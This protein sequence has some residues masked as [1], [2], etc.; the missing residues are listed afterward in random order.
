MKIAQF[1][2]FSFEG[3]N[4]HTT[5]NTSSN[6]WFQTGDVCKVRAIANSR[7]TLTRPEQETRSA[8]PPAETAFRLNRGQQILSLWAMRNDGHGLF[9]A[10]ARADAA[11]LTAKGHGNLAPD[12]PKH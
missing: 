2:Q 9:H 6:P 7:H 12:L 5:V 10:A 8:L 1:Q 11:M 4:T 3:C